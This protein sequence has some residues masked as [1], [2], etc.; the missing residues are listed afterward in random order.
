MK[1]DRYG[2]WS[3][4]M[5]HHHGWQSATEADAS[6]IPKDRR[7]G[8]CSAREWSETSWTPR[9]KCAACGATTLLAT[10]RDWSARPEPLSREVGNAICEA[11]HRAGMRRGVAA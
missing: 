1:A 11:L 3:E 6:S 7:C 9:P 10:C 8:D 2:T 5:R 4:Q